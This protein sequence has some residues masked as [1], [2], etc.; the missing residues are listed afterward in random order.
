M[1]SKIAKKE[2]WKLFFGK[3][4]DGRS[5]LTKVNISKN[6][7]KSTSFFDLVLFYIFLFNLLFFFSLRVRALL[8]LSFL[9]SSHFFKKSFVSV[10]SI[11][12]LFFCCLLF[13]LSTLIFSTVSS[14]FHLLCLLDSLF[15]SLS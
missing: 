1:K 10:S 7:R 13:L 6:F 14:L 15:S 3:R 2:I 11:C 4:K 9:F 5:K 12:C 8:L